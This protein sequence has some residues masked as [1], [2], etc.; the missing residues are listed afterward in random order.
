MLGDAVRC[1]YCNGP[2]VITEIVETS[3]DDMMPVACVNCDAIFACSDAESL[4]HC[5]I[6]HKA[7]CLNS[8][9][10]TLTL[11]IH[12]GDKLGEF[13]GCKFCS[14]EELVVG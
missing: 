13:K 1:P 7:S 5:P 4:D 12:R 8:G 6:V 9:D 14:Y 2:H 10:H 11:I 3:G